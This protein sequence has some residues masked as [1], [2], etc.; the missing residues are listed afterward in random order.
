MAKIQ[1]LPEQLINQIAAGEVVER[2][3]SV[4]KELIE[5]ALDAEPKEIIVEIKD[6]GQTFVRVSDNGSGMDKVN[7]LK[8]LERHATSKIASFEDLFSIKS[9]GFRGEALASIA[10]VSE[11][12]IKTKKQ[13]DLIGTEIKTEGGEIKSISEVGCKEGTQVEVKNLF[14][15]T[16]ARK[17][18]LKNEN[19]EYQHILETVLSNAIAF[20]EIAFKFINNDKLVL[21]LPATND[22]LVRIRGTLGKQIADELIPV[23]YGGVHISLQGFIGKPLLAR[24]SK[25]LQYL[26]V[27][28]RPIRSHVLSYAVKEAYHS[29]LSREKYPVFILKFELQPS[30][31]DVNVHPRK[32][33]VKFVD[34][35]EIFRVLSQACGKALE[36]HILAPKINSETPLNYYQERKAQSFDV[37]SKTSNDASIRETSAMIKNTEKETNIFNLEFGAQIENSPQLVKAALSFTKELAEPLK[38]QQTEPNFY[39]LSHPEATQLIEKNLSEE[40]YVENKFPELSETQFIFQDRK[41]EEELV[42]LGQL[43]NSFILCNQGRNLVIVDQH[44][45]HERIRYT[46][47]M[48]HSQQQEKN[49]QPLLTPLSIELN[50]QDIALLN[51]QKDLLENLGFLIS[52]FGGNS[53]LIEAV[54]AFIVKENLDEILLGLLD[55]LR[56]DNSRTELDIRKEKILT[57]LAC[58]SAVKFGDSLSTEEQKALVEKLQTLAL[59]YTCPH[60]RPTMIIMTKDEL[61]QRFGR[62]YC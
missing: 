59:P 46:E 61:W 25:N 10:S 9:M 51:A 20:P 62:K 18:Y 50:Q 31:V 58:R 5:N 37:S 19:T 47:L 11:L 35:K 27:N 41:F 32:T 1:T 24:A 45:A 23:F 42:P 43:D 29:L 13:G 56:E 14:F 57:Y 16:P 22:E 17:K 30:L 15:N 52:H 12:N 8:C 28:K 33:E 6:G 4:I 26:F 49:V 44:A 21:E 38:T 39:S 54:P 55:D 3:A 36:K 2:P 40:N 53:F 48:E 7:A 60:G 34:E